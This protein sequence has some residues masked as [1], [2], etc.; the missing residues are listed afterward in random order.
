M[1]VNKFAAFAV[2][3]VAL[4]ASAVA[5]CPEALA[6][7]F[8]AKV[9]SVVD[10]DTIN[11]SVNGAAREKVILYG[12]DCPELTQEFGQNARQFTDQACFRKD[13]TI[14][15]KSKDPHGRL[16]AVVTL[17]D[18]TNLNQALVAHGLA[19]WSDKYAAKD[20]TL[21]GLHEQAKAAHKGLWAAPNPVAPW[22][23]RNGAK[24]VQAEIK[25]K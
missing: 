24:D 20:T 13:V 17:A 11:V 23:F 3:V 12:I 16:I 25:L 6:E 9:V 10:G 18:G 15:V 8:T 5:L 19:W 22:I 7:T 21:K 14:D 1:P 2:A 4:L